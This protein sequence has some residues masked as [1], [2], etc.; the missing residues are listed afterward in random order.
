[1]VMKLHNLILSLFIACSIGFFSCN[2]DDD[3]IPPGQT[4]VVE[5]TSEV[6]G[7]L[8]VRVFYYNS[9]NVNPTPTGTVV[10]LYGTYEDAINQSHKLAIYSL[11]TSDNQAYFGYINYGNYYVGASANI[12]GFNYSG[13]SIVQVR[14]RRDE[15]LSLTMY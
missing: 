10:N 4:I 2:S 1:M 14:P 11:Y 7:T 15:I 13:L 9:G 5:D 12:F 6:T 3:V 8:T